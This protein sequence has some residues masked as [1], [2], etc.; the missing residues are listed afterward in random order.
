MATVIVSNRPELESALDSREEDI[1]VMGSFACQLIRGS[2]AGN[3]LRDL[4]LRLGREN[5]RLEGFIVAANVVKLI[6][7]RV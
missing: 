7:K 1:L 3:Y 6:K 2:K 5:Y 4:V